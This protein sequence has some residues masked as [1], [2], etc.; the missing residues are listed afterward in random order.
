M[1]MMWTVMAWMLMM[2]TILIPRRGVARAVSVWDH[3]GASVVVVGLRPRARRWWWWARWWDYDHDGASVT[4]R[5]PFPPKTTDS[6]VKIL[7]AWVKGLHLPIGAG[8][9]PPVLMAE[10]RLSMMTERGN[11]REGKSVL[12]L[13]LPRPSRRSVLGLEQL[14]REPRAIRRQEVSKPP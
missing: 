8:P 9:V 6:S 1:L 5:T 7:V 11:S 2:R 4:V 10:L 14:L 3:D 13:P 12:L